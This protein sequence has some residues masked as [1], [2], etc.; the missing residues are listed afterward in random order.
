MV[1]TTPLI[2]CEDRGGSYHVLHANEAFASLAGVARHTF[3]GKDMEAAL[4][5]AVNAQS[6]GALAAPMAEHVSFR[7]TLRAV[8]AQA[9]VGAPIPPGNTAPQLWVLWIDIDGGVAVPSGLD[10]LPVGLVL[11]DADDCLTWCNNTYRRVLGKNA[12]L[13]KTGARFECIMSAAYRAGHAAGGAADAEQR[14]A[15]RLARHHNHESFEEALSGDRW[16]LT[17]EIALADGGILGVR[18]DITEAKRRQATAGAGA[19]KR[20]VR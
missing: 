5:C 10:D 13:L 9:L 16:L 19:E 14:I 20:T 17:E 12:H 11:F 7:L 3:A 15:E 2:I 1:A 18:T 4:A 8:S 6:G